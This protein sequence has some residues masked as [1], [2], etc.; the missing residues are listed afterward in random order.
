MLRQIKYFQAVV[1]HHSFSEAAQECHISQSAISQ[2]I[3]SLER[4][5]GFQLLERKNRSFVLTPAGEHFYKKSLVLVADYEKL[6]QE[7]L[8]I[9]RGD[10]AVLKIGYLRSYSGHE[11]HLALE[12]FSTKYPLVS[13]QL[14][15]GNHE[16]LFHMLRNGEAD[17]VLND[18][19]RAF[20]DEYINLILTTNNEYIEITSRNPMSQLSSITPQELKNI[21]CIL[22]ASKEQQETEREYYQSV[23]GFQG[24]FIYAEN[25]E[26]AR[27]MVIGGQGFMPVEGSG[28]KLNFTTSICRIPLH[29]GNSQITRKYCLFWKKDNSGYY[30]E[31]FAEILKS[32]F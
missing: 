19:R 28:E 8:K 13:V 22:V 9:A 1:R 25:L 29:R 31:E 14:I 21:P 27:L 23:I 18:Q 6:C 17:L 5:L 3:Q 7:S 4:E 2:Q 32:K 24:E 26:E 15:Y 10:E 12:E 16:D 20:S 11:F 30:I